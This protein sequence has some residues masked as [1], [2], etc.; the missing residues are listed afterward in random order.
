MEKSG[1]LVLFLFHWNIYCKRQ[2]RNKEAKRLNLITK[3]VHMNRCNGREVKQ[4]TLD[5]DFNVPDARPDALQI[6]K[7]Q[8]EVQI[9][10]VHMMEGKASVKGLLHFQI[11]YASDGDI[12]VS[13]M[14]GT[15]PFEETILLPQAK[16]ED[17]ISVQA[18]I[19][20]LKSELI[21]SRKLGMKAIVVLNVTAGSV[22]DGEGAIDIEGGED[23]YTKKRTAEVSYLIFSKK[24]TLRVRDEWKIPGTKDAMQRILYSDVCIGELNARMEE[25][26][27]LVEG[28]A[29]VFVIYLGE[30]ENPSINYFENTLPIEGHIDCHGCNADMVEQ[31]TAS[32][33][34]R[35]LGVKEDEDGEFRV[36]EVEV[37]FAFD[38]K[39]YGQEKIDLLTDFYSLKEKCKPVY[40]PSYFENLKIHN[41]SKCRFTGMVTAGE[42]VPLQIWNVSGSLFIDH[43]EQKEEGLLVRGALLVSVL[44]QTGDERV[45]LAT[46]KGT[47]PFEQLLEA[48]GLTNNSHINLHGMLE[49]VSASLTGEKEIEIKAVA[50]L[51]LLVFDRMEEP[52]VSGYESE[53]VD[54]DAFRSAPG[55][56]GYV[57][58][59]KETLWDIAKKFFTTVEAIMEV[60]QK[61]TEQVQTGDMILILKE[62]S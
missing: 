11:L 4:L 6:M 56:V 39:V 25:E 17:E 55:M 47:I 15:I 23:I 24:D 44:Y 51:D 16:A 26:K 53:E 8:G 21:N 1:L 3:R 32:I 52:I 22:C 59:E 35:D 41:K 58:Q 60:N 33:H 54:W 29:N 31:V 28:Q 12:P 42:F 57:V 5:R 7:E 37:V 50:A 34:S 61:E 10:E 20:D 30:G 27:L 62:V 19:G 43:K 48:N 38:M 49:Q 2:L 9:E 18:E 36:L 14:T 13:E 46:A 40:E 45:P